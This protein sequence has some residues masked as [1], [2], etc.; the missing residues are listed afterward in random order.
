[1][2]SFA[3]LRFYF[4]FFLL[5]VKKAFKEQ[6]NCFRS[7][8]LLLFAFFVSLSLAW[9][10]GFHGAVVFCHHERYQGYSAKQLCAAIY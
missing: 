10:S 5:F 7:I 8:F 4:F 2:P 3:A 9:R 1:M 6:I